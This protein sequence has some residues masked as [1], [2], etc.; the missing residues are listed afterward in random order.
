MRVVFSVLG[1][2]ALFVIGGLIALQQSPYGKIFLPTG[3]GITAKQICSLHFVSGLDP[4][5]ARAMYVTP[6]LGDADGLISTRVDDSDGSVEAKVRVLGFTQRA[7][8]REGLGCTLV[9]GDTRHDH[10]LAMPFTSDAPLMS[11]DAALRD[12]RFDVEALNT[13]I[14]IAFTDDGRNTLAVAVLYQGTLIAE[15]YADGVTARSPLHGWSMSKSLAATYAGVLVQQNLVDIYAPGQIEALN[16]VGPQTEGLTIDHLLRMTGGLAGHE[17]QDGV[18]P[19]SDMLF[20]E[21]DMAQFAATREILYAP[22]E[23]WEYQSG[24]T[25][26]AGMG[27]Q[28]QIEGGLE[29]D[30]THLRKSLLEPLGMFDTVVES[31]EAGALQWSSYVYASAQDW[32]KLGQLYLDGG[33]VGDDQI[34]PEDWIDYITTP[35]QGSDEQYGSG[36]WINQ[37]GL[38]DDAFVMNGFQSQRG[39][40]IPSEDLVVVRLGATNGVNEGAYKLA[41]DIVAAKL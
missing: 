34:I 15:R 3:T 14:D 28:D 38:P 21:S 24:N 2:I 27:L 22:G 18:D 13:A 31:D 26:L 11:V 23:Y 35:T 33:R 5:R 29:A 6:L 32:A 7:E 12:A 41:R 16:A 1:L 39:I 30:L 17:R 25:I 4:E 8:Y 37:S 36:Y 10:Q 19:N 20:T 9:H 40:I